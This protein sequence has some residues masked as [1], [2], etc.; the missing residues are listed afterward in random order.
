MRDGSGH[1]NAHSQALGIN[2]TQ[3]M[4]LAHISRALFDELAAG[5]NSFAAWRWRAAASGKSLAPVPTARAAR[6]RRSARS[7]RARMPLIAAGL[8]AAGGALVYFAGS[9]TQEKLVKL[10]ELMR[11]RRCA[12]M[13]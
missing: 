8:T 11:S 3:A 1:V 7:L 6:C 9:A 5:S 4:E 13:S 12:P 2:R 10:G